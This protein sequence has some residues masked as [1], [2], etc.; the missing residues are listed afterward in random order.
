VNDLH[1]T[2]KIRQDAV[3]RRRHVLF[4]SG[5]GQFIFGPFGA[6]AFLEKLNR[7]KNVHTYD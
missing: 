7:K 1:P 6:A 3:N 5:R 4:L 2:N